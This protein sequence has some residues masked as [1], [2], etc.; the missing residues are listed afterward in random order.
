MCDGVTR[1]RPNGH[2]QSGS[3]FV[4]LLLLCVKDGEVVVR[5][6]QLRKIFGELG[7]D[8]NGVRRTPQFG[9]N[10][11][12]HETTLGILGLRRD[13]GVGL[14]QRLRHLPLLHQTLNIRQRLR[15]AD[16][17]KNAQCKTGKNDRKARQ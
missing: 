12:A 4:I 7:E 10:Q 2:L 11:P 3:G 16:R 5:F 6:R 8:C 1:M 14:F 13:V 15:V 9:Q 17:C